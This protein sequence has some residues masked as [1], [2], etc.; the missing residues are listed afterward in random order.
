MEVINVLKDL[1]DRHAC[2]GNGQGRTII[3]CVDGVTRC[4]L[5]VTYNNVMEM[6]SSSQ[7]IDVCF[8]TKQVRDGRPQA[9]KKIHQ[10]KAV[11]DWVMS[12]VD[13]QGDY[14]NM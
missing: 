10:F 6:V 9:I 2:E 8:A 3:Q 5:Y 11:H 14:Y 4:G 1:V 7:R 13:A 12:S